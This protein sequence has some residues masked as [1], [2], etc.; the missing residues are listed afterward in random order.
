[1]AKSPV[2][3]AID[4]ETANYQGYSAC[5]VGLVRIRNQEV[6]AE[7]YSL[8]KPPSSNIL[9]TQYHGLTWDDLKNASDFPSVWPD[10]ASIIDGATYLVAHNAPFDRRI[11]TACCQKFG[12]Q[13]PRQPFLDT[14]RGA[15]HAYNLPSH[16][17]NIVCDYL[18]IPLEHHNAASDAIACAR[19]FLHLVN[20]MKIDP[21]FLKLA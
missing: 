8:I 9:F 3:V 16:K 14:L 15:R 18:G 2:V 1:M 11:L 10:I 17:L 20:K 12:I 6:E 5:A 13:T 4:F 19:L 7:Y 21:N